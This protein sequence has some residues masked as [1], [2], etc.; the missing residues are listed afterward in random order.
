M[1]I[2]R[3]NRKWVYADKCVNSDSPEPPQ[4]K[5]IVFRDVAFPAETESELILPESVTNA[6]VFVTVQPRMS[7]EIGPA[8][9]DLGVG[10]NR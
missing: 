10:G 8:T 4:T 1:G 3:I 2:T 5:P 7:T 6:I 9:F